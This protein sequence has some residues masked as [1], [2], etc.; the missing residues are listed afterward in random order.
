MDQFSPIET[1]EEVHY[2]KWKSRFC[3]QISFAVEMTLTNVGASLGPQHIWVNVYATRDKHESL[4]QT[5]SR[6][7]QT[8]ITH[9][10][11]VQTQKIIC[12]MSLSS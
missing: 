9:R 10:M 2:M 7:I 3:A 6:S 8:S 11:C 5:I 12:Q 4:V 1:S